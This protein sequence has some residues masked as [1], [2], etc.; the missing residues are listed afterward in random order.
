[1]GGPKDLRFFGPLRL[2]RLKVQA[3]SPCRP[4]RNHN[5]PSMRPVFTNI[6]AQLVRW[7]ISFPTWKWSDGFRHNGQ[8]RMVRG[9]VGLCDRIGFQPK[10]L[11]D[12][13]AFDSEW[14]HALLRF[15]PGTRVTSIEPLHTKNTIGE[16][17]K[18]ALSDADGAGEIE[19]LGKR[20]AVQIKRFDSLG[21]RIDQPAILKVDCESDTA[22][23]LRGFGDQLD[24]FKVVVAEMWNDYRAEWGWRNDTGLQGEIWEIMLAHGFRMAQVVDVPYYTDGVY[25]YDIA[26][27][28]R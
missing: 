22:K 14:A 9:V 24:Q 13:G 19:Y 1:M 23:A 27:F 6:Y 4:E 8:R 10:H 28:K 5:N 25:W 18:V 15:W 21:V 11:V 20:E 3:D 7:A 2:E 12:C 17:H 16:V 26:F